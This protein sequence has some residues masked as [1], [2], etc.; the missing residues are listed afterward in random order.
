MVAL[1]ISIT[2]TLVYTVKSPRIQL[3]LVLTKSP[4]IANLADFALT[5]LLIA[6][7]PTF[8][9]STDLGTKEAVE[10][11]IAGS[12][13]IWPSPA[14]C[15]VSFIADASRRIAPTFSAVAFLR[16]ISAEG[17]ISAAFCGLRIGHF[18]STM[19]LII[20]P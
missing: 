13:T 2:V 14:K 20:N 8:A 7:F 15:A 10:A 17:S 5:C 3:A 19:M 4:L 11:I 9:K 12:L 18:L 1:D 16:A 6:R